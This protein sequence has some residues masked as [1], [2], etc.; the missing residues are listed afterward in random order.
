M[1]I[2]QLT[3]RKRTFYVLCREYLS[4]FNIAHQLSRPTAPSAA[5][6]PNLAVV[7]PSVVHSLIDH[8]KGTRQ[9]TTRMWA[10]DQRDGRPAEYRW[11]PLFNAAQFG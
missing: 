7:L 9:N 6:K 2:E 8:L 5:V 4:V 11:R 10:G 3:E 1:F